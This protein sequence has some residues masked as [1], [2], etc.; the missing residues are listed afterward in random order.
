MAVNPN[1]TNAN[2]TTPFASG[3][4][5]GLNPTFN[6]VTI[7]QGGDINMGSSVNSATSMVWNYDVSGTLQLFQTMAYFGSNFGQPSS[8]VLFNIDQSAGADNQGFG[9]L[10]IAGKGESLQ[11]SFNAI[12]IGKS[13]TGVL[14]IRNVA[15]ATG[16]INA[17][18]AELLPTSWTLNGVS[19]INAG[20]YTANAVNLLS[21]LQGTFPTS[22]A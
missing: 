6:S 4:G 17:T 12:N 11:G 3:G 14:G 2:A 13:G 1:F 9:D 8:L 20:A 19:T 7:N 18:Y 16:A 10:L 21:S 5:G 22:F 15:R